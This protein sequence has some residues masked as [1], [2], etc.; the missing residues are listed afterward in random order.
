MLHDEW[1]RSLSPS[2]PLLF[3]RDGISLKRPHYVFSH[4]EF[5]RRDV[6][7][8]RGRSIYRSLVRG[9]NAHVIF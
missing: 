8:K 3:A 1:Q 4:K 7:R 5:A 6:Q 2:L 9:L